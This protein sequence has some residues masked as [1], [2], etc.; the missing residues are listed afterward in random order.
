MAHNTRVTEVTQTPTCSSADERGL[1]GRTRRMIDC[2]ISENSRLPKRAY[3]MTPESTPNAPAEMACIQTVANVAA[4]DT[5][6]TTPK[7]TYAPAPTNAAAVM[8]SQNE[9]AMRL[10]NP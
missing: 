9:R 3:A 8:L 2:P 6:P 7:T 4:G 5:V 10:V 1:G